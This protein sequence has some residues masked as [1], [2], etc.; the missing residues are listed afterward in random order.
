MTNDDRAELLAFLKEHG[1]DEEKSEKF[2]EDRIGTRLLQIPG[3]CLLSVLKEVCQEGIPVGT[4][5]V[6]FLV[7]QGNWDAF[8]KRAEDAIAKFGGFVFTP[9]EKAALA[10]VDPETVH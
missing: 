1:W 9:E 10:N 8:K 2:L 4:I 7:P 3:K 5:T 6:A